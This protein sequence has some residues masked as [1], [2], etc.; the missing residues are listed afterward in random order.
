[1]EAVANAVAELDREATT[2]LDAWLEEA[3]GQPLPEPQKLADE[4]AGLEE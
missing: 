2:R 3:E 4:L 1:M